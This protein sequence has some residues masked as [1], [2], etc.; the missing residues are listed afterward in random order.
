MFI[1][2]V[3]YGQLSPAVMDDILLNVHNS[4]NKSQVLKKVRKGKFIETGD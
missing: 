4:D 2:A 3:D 1:L